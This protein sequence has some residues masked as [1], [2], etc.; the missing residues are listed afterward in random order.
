M[1]LYIQLGTLRP[2]LELI[3][4]HILIIDTHITHIIAMWMQIVTQLSHTHISLA[5]VPK[6][7]PM[8][9]ERRH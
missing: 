1:C 2:T 5:I 6:D 8:I 9:P 7:V 4:L 3:M